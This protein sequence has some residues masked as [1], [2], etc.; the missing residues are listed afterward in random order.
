MAERIDARIW[1]H[2][3]LFVLLV[4]AIIVFQL[5]PLDLRPASIA[6]PDVLLAVTLVWVVRRPLVAPVLLIAAVFL[7]A[8][9]LFLRPPGLWA[10]LVVLLT[11]FLR[12][13]NR[14]LRN[15]PLIAEWG[16]VAIGIVAI[17]VLN[18]LILFLVLGPV[19]P[20]APT[21]V[22]MAGTIVIYPFIVFLAHYVFGIRRAALGEV[23]SKG[24]RL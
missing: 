4:F 21:L 16:T 13:Q 19:T 6:T 11:E 3:G 15:M 18:R 12:R 1:A 8:D 7:L 10:A 2:R 14:E 24:Q 22:Q 17:T 9:M 20:L 23:G 5:V